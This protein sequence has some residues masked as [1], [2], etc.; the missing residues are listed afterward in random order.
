MWKIHAMY[1]FKL[2]YILP[3]TCYTLQNPQHVIDFGCSLVAST[4]FIFTSFQVTVYKKQTSM[5]M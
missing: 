2:Q 3:V 4:S 1:S 5:N